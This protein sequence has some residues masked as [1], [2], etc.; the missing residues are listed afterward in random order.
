MISRNFLD[1]MPNK[2]NIKD[3]SGYHSRSKS[4]KKL[5]GTSQ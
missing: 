1:I 4:L 3:F 5:H 2:Y